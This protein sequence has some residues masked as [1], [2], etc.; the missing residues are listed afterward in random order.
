MVMEELFFELLR[1][2]LFRQE[3]LSR[4]PSSFEWEHLYS[5]AN[6]QALLGVCFSAISRLPN[7]QRPPLDLYNMWLAQTAQIVQQNE[8]HTNVLVRVS[9]YLREKSIDA[10]FMK[11]LICASRYPQPELRQSGDIDFVVSEELYVRTLRTLED[12][13]SVN[14]ELK[15]EHHG[16]AWVD[17]ILLE[18]HFK[19][20]NFQNPKNDKTMRQLQK[21]VLD[22]APCYVK[23]SENRIRKFPIEFEGMLLLSHL[24]NHVYEEGL[25]LRQVMDYYYWLQTFNGNKELFLSYLGKMHMRRAARIF[26]II[27]ELY[28]GL[29]IGKGCLETPSPKEIQFAKKLMADIMRVG[30][31]GREYYH[32]TVKGIGDVFKNYVWVFRRSVSLAYLCPSEAH[33]W[34]YGKMYR[35]IKKH[36]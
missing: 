8:L 30:N 36:I 11:G 18:P 1:V 35:F 6:K 24:V 17:G 22:G 29:E 27:T 25:G 10:V 34:P 33:W 28:L 16:M 31:F 14:H 13:G 15:H 32:S 21:E 23:I 20:H 12:L 26:G 3:L 9:S 5:I 4:K 19:L 7:S 2:A